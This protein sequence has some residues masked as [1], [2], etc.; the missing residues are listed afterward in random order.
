[1][2][3]YVNSWGILHYKHNTC[4][5]L[6]ANEQRFVA[7]F[8][9]KSKFNLHGWPGQYANHM[10]R[11]HLCKAPKIIFSIKYPACWINHVLSTH[12]TILTVAA[13]QTI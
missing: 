5:G 3:Q 11:W 1:M 2:L 7:Y 8:D 12:L 4:W 9:I 6:S 10:Y 13:N